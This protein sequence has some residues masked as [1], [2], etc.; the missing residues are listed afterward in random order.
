M[1]SRT[2]ISVVVEFEVDTDAANRLEP[3]DG[4][5]ASPDEAEA[6]IPGVL[7]LGRYL[8]G[9]MAGDALAGIATELDPIV[10]L[11]RVTVDEIEDDGVF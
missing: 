6:P 8:G 7:A 2:R 10:G 1:K 11:I 3:V 9:M 5:M 4:F